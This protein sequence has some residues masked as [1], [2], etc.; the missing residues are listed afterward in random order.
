M[1]YSW[2]TDVTLLMEINMI[3]IDDLTLIFFKSDLR[4]MAIPVTPANSKHR[5]RVNI[6]EW[7]ELP[8]CLYS[9]IVSENCPSCVISATQHG[10]NVL[11]VIRQH[12]EYNYVLDL[13]I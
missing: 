9:C 6:C 5:E 12:S 11:A 1:C 13:C 4:N 3:R 10:D 8:A 2:H 7:V